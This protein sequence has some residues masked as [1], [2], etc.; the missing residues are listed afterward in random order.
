MEQK[1]LASWLKFILIGI[2]L[3]GLLLYAVILPVYGHDLVESYPEFENRYL[4]WLIF[5]WVSGVPCFVVLWLGWRVVS[6]IGMDRSFCLENAASLKRV[7]YLAGGDTAYFLTGNIVLLLLD[8]SHPGVFLGSMLVCFA[9]IA[10]TVAAA[11]L[12][13]LVMKAALLQDQA[14]LTV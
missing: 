5:L 3:C 8:M 10:V 11:A 6:N 1:T 7:S 14:D 4:P 9:G 13:H 2:G 12:S